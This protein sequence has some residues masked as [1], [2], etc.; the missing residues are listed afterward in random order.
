MQANGGPRNSKPGTLNALFFTAIEKH[1]K[2]NALQVK[3][4][5]A[6]QSI[7]SSELADRVRQVGLGLGA[8]GIKRGDR[9]AI[10]SENR[11][12]WAIVDYAALTA[13]L[14]DVPIYP[15][16]PA[17]QIPHILNDSGSV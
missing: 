2:P 9:V 13:G 7:S 17:E 16:L 6:Y 1:N 14:T 11:P 12:E 5:G 3:R 8:L 10:L 15:T 4:G